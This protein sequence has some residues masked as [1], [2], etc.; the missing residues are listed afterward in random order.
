MADRRIDGWLVYDFRN[1]SQVLARLLPHPGTHRRHVTRRLMLFIP[2]AGRPQ[3]LVHTLD[4]NQFEGRYSPSA[5]LNIDIQRYTRWQELVAWIG[6]VVTSSGPRIAL[7]YVPGCALP[8]MSVTDA[9]T[10]DMVRAAGAEVVSSA[11]LVQVS[12]ARWGAEAARRH[13]DASVKVNA[14]KDDAFRFIS[15]ALAAG[16]PVHE[17]DAVEQ[18]RANFQS[19]GLEWPDGPIVAVN[20]HAGDPHYEPGA[21]KP[22]PIRRGDVVLIDLWARIPGDENIHSDI[23][24]MAVAGKPSSLQQ[25]VFDA[26]RRARDAAV[27]LAQSCWKAGRTVRG[28]ELD[29]AARLEL[30]SA[31]HGRFAAYI[32]HRT[33][34]SLSP[35]PLVHGMGMNLDNLETHDTREMLP[36]TGFTVEPGLYLPEFGVRLEINLYVDPRQGPVITSRVQDAFI[37]I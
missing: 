15:A 34:H 8:V 33:G 24:W 20:A 36:D 4:A 19:K 22:T 18:I 14:V 13:G 26:V 2:A 6:K 31:D 25:S 12:A 29:D 16:R 28:W 23:T 5:A 37:E 11:D 1:S 7:E 27:D 35:G 9:G 10:I 17:Y 3:L 21:D 30:E 32:R